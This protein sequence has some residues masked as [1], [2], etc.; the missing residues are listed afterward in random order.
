MRTYYL[1]VQTYQIDSHLT[2][3][4]SQNANTISPPSLHHATSSGSLATSLS[5]TPA[6]LVP[7]PSSN[8]A[9]NQHQSLFTPYSLF[10]EPSSLREP[11]ANTPS[12]FRFLLKCSFLRE[13]FSPGSS[14]LLH[15]SPEYAWTPGILYIY[16]FIHLCPSL[17]PRMN[18]NSIGVLISVYNLTDV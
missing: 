9:D 8:T 11:H 7:M 3:H 14:F 17:L 2:Q 12:P 18:V 16:S 4:E 15:F 1:S 6:T 13:A 10:L 5:L